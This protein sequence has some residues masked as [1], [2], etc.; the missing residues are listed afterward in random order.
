M[1]VFDQSGQSPPRRRSAAGIVV[2]TTAAN[3][4]AHCL[5]ATAKMGLNDWALPYPSSIAGNV[6]DE[7][8]LLWQVVPSDRALVRHL[9]G[10]R[11][12]PTESGDHEPRQLAAITNR[13][14]TD[15]A[16][17]TQSCKTHL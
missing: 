2:A 17:G 12:P 1:K 7:V 15:R 9:E 3:L 5:N 13:K 8:H 6:P 11:G 4:V 16:G 14:P 10:N